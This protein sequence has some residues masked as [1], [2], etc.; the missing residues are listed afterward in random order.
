[1][2]SQLLNKRAEPD[3]IDQSKTANRGQATPNVHLSIYK[4]S[5]K[6]KAIYHTPENFGREDNEN[7]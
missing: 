4:K 5:I 3:F 6:I 2:I 7:H 1:M